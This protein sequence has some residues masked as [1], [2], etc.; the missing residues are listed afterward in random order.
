MVDVVTK[1]DFD[2]AILALQT[3]LDVLT[4]KVTALQAGEIPEEVKAAIGV[5]AAYL[6]G[7]P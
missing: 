1:T 7:L 4:D 3:Q 6:A 5:I 2:A